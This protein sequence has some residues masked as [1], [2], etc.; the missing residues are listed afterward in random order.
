MNFYIIW[1]KHVLY[2]AAN[3]PFTKLTSVISCQL[4]LH[5]FYNYYYYFI[6]NLA[7][8]IRRLTLLLFFAMPR[9]EATGR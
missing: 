6:T 3:L 4:S 1:K 8:L 2:K 7:W 9:D 5:L